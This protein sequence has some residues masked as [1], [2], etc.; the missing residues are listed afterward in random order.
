MVSLRASLRHGT[1]GAL[2]LL[3]VGG[4]CTPASAFGADLTPSANLSKI[5]YDPSTG[6]TESATLRTRTTVLDG[7]APLSAVE[8]DFLEEASESELAT[9][10]LR[11]AQGAL[12]ELGLLMEDDGAL[13][14]SFGGPL[15]SQGRDAALL[16]SIIV[17]REQGAR[18][19]DLIQ[20]LVNEQLWSVAAAHKLQQDHQPLHFGYGIYAQFRGSELQ[21]IG[22][23]ISGRLRF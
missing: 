9:S 10:S 23:G 19:E 22:I 4:V 14:L 16:N 3:S 12:S 7:Y 20:S 11:R 6:S 18:A 21:H 17:E 13:S 1:L 5:Q 15:Q 8:T 2:L